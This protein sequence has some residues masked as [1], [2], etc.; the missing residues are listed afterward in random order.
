MVG[1]SDCFGRALNVCTFG[2]L[3][4]KNGGALKDRIDGSK[5]W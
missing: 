2:F 3:L 1:V 4:A 5:S